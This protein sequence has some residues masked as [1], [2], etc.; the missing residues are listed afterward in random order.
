MRKHFPV[1][2]LFSLDIRH[3]PETALLQTAIGLLKQDLGGALTTQHPAQRS[4][5]SSCG[6][7]QS[8]PTAP[9]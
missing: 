3:H 1:C 4:P 2:S 6:S 9:R 7:L 8:Y 5:E